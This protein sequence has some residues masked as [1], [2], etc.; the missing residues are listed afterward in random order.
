MTVSFSTIPP[1]LKIPLFY[2]EFDNS[3]AGAN[4]PNQRALIFG[5]AI[6]AGGGTPS[7]VWVSSPAAAASQFGAASQLAAEVAA[8]RANDP[9]TELWTMPYAD[10]AA[11]VAASGSVAF[12]GTA[13]APGVIPLRVGGVSVA[14]TIAAGDTAA[15]AAAKVLATMQ[16]TPSLPVAP[17]GS[18]GM[19]TLTAANKG[20]L[21]NS[22]PISMAYYGARGGEVMPPGLTY[23]ITAMSGGSGDPDLSGLAAAIAAMDFDF[24]VSPW[25][26]AAELAVTTAMMNDTSG[27]WSYKAALY[28]HVF[29]AKQD[30]AANLL[31]FGNTLNDPHL[32]VLGTYG[33]P[34]PDYVWAAAFAGAVAPPIKAD[35]A[36]PVQTIPI[37][38]V[39]GPPE[40]KLFAWDNNQALLSNGI[41]LPLVG[42]D[43]SVA[44]M[45]CVTTYQVNRYGTPDQSHLDYETLATLAEITRRLKAATTRK[46]PRAKL[47][48]DGTRFGPGQPVVTPSIYKAEI[49][50]QYRQMEFDG[51]VEDADAM[52]KATIVERNA[53]DP[54]RLDVLWAPY[55]VSGLRIVALLNQFRLLSAEATT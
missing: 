11:S 43:G 5:Q 41:A 21:G 13:T 37:L 7:P 9:A 42:Q 30:T 16:A 14:T 24:I 34:T 38:G 17:T 22:I 49:I 18:S 45:R 1:D 35:P 54:S 55:L 40:E 19:L 28:G 53:R 3:M 12:A 36:R 46:F 50:S 26:S 8:Y 29:T 33:S 4:L 32:S 47:A 15:A 51:L 2:A 39:L 48:D 23:T 6:G 52:A 10:A 20:T 27:R 25:T 44:I 31:A